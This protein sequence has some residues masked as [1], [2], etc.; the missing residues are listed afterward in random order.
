MSGPDGE[1]CNKCYYW[2]TPNTDRGFCYRYPDSANDI[3]FTKWC[4][5]FKPLDKSERVV[6]DRELFE[7]RSKE[8]IE[9]FKKIEADK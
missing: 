8:V 4:G 1:L 2:E 5:E 6:F 7:K 9:L 3:M